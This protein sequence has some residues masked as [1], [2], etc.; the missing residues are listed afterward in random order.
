VAK[1]AWQHDRHCPGRTIA[2]VSAVAADIPV[3][4]A[5]YG[6][7]VTV[8]GTSVSAPFISG[9]FGLAGN[10]TS[11]TPRYLY[12]HAADFLDITHGNN[13]LVGGPTAACGGD[14]L[15]KARKGYDA[16]TGLGTPDGIAGF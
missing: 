7:W 16:P 5:F 1:P 3:F 15:C 14:Y 11:I 12:Q 13:L 6:G 10:A 8:A 9:V 2:D 4:N